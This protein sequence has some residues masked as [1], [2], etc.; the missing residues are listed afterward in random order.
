MET[1]RVLLLSLLAATAACSR[2]PSNECPTRITVQL[3]TVSTTLVWDSMGVSAHLVSAVGDCL[4]V[5][6]VK[7]R[8][9]DS[10]TWYRMPITML[11]RGT[12]ENP[13]NYDYWASGGNISPG[14]LYMEAVGG[15]GVVLKRDSISFRFAISAPGQRVNAAL[16]YLSPD[17]IKHVTKLRVGFLPHCASGS[18]GP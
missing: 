7:N 3:D 11:V 8:A 2:S 15:N 18:C 16:N 10:T 5:H 12:Q 14:W 4:P 13:T 1:M 9:E 17:E 6:T